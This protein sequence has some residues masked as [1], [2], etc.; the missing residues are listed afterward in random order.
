MGSTASWGAQ[1]R[2][3]STIIDGSGP[4]YNHQ[5]TRQH[6]I[7]SVPCPLLQPSKCLGTGSANIGEP[8]EDFHSCRV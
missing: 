6:A 8:L 1:R 7:G 4:E 3:D 2:A 5:Q